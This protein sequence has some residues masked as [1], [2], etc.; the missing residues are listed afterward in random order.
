[1]VKRAEIDDIARDG[2]FAVVEEFAQAGEAEETAVGLRIVELV[3]EE[4]VVMMEA[5]EGRAG[6][7]DVVGAVEEG[8]AGRLGR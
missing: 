4:G 2:G 6:G 8:A 5:S 7:D 3:A 1:M